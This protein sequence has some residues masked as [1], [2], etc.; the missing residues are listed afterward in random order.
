MRID[1][2]SPEHPYRQLAGAPPARRCAILR[3]PF[4]TLDHES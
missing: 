4:G 3:D 2:A 1:P